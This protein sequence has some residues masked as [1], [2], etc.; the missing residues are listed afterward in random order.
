MRAP[1]FVYSAFQLLRCP[2]GSGS[3]SSSRPAGTPVSKFIPMQ[4]GLMTINRGALDK[5]Q[6]TIGSTM[7]LGI[8]AFAF[9]F[10]AFVFLFP[11]G[12]FKGTSIC[13]FRALIVSLSSFPQGLCGEAFVTGFSTPKPDPDPD[14]RLFFSGFAVGPVKYPV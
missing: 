2:D 1:L 5:P 14:F 10:F 11:M 3:K 13:L 6:I 7:C 12:S 9:L 8:L 4:S